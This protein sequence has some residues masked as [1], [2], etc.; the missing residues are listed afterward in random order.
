MNRRLR[1]KVAAA[2]L[3]EMIVYVALFG[4]IFISV[5]EFTLTMQEYDQNAV[6]YNDL[7]RSAVFVNQH[8][9]QTFRQGKLIKPATSVFDNDNG[10]LVLTSTNNIDITYKL[11]N[12]ELM[13]NRSSVDNPI[14]PSSIRVTK[15]RF[16]KI[17]DSE[18]K[19]VGTEIEYRLELK[20]EPQVNKIYKT[21]YVLPL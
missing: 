5:V 19:E 16:T 9:R 20:Q 4:V 11:V 13:I 8:I 15:L 12:G 6:Y 14:T 7:E 1:R 3:L 18:G 2:T 10:Q 17:V 21:N